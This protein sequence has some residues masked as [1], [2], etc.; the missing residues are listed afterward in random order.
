MSQASAALLYRRLLMA[1]RLA[2]IRPFLIPHLHLIS[3]RSVHTSNQPPSHQVTQQPNQ[4]NH[5]HNNNNN[6]NSNHHRRQKEI[7]WSKLGVLNEKPPSDADASWLIDQLKLTLDAQSIKGMPRK[8]VFMMHASIVS[9][10]LLGGIEPKAVV[11]YLCVFYRQFASLS[12]RLHLL[13]VLNIYAENI[14]QQRE[15]LRPKYDF[16]IVPGSMPANRVI[17]FIYRQLFAPNSDITGDN[18][19]ELMDAIIAEIARDDNSL[20]EVTR[21]NIGESLAKMDGRFAKEDP[22]IYNYIAANVGKI[23]EKAQASVKRGLIFRLKQMLQRKDT[24]YDKLLEF[25]DG[26]VPQKNPVTLY[27]DIMGKIISMTPDDH[28]IEILLK[29]IR[30][31]LVPVN[32]KELE[33]SVYKALKGDDSRL[34]YTIL[35]G[36]EPPMQLNM[37]SRMRQMTEDVDDSSLDSLIKEPLT[38]EESDLIAKFY[39]R[40]IISVIL[41]SYWIPQRDPERCKEYLEVLKRNITLATNR[42][43]QNL[44]LYNELVLYT[45]IYLGKFFSYKQ[46]DEELTKNQSKELYGLKDLPS[47]VSGLENRLDEYHMKHLPRWLVYTIHHHNLT[48]ILAYMDPKLRLYYMGIFFPKSVELFKSLGLMDI[49]EIDPAQ[50]SESATPRYKSLVLPEAGLHV[51]QLTFLYKDIFIN[52]GDKISQSDA[53]DLFAKLTNYMSSHTDSPLFE[54]KNIPA[55]LDRFIAFGSIR[56]YSQLLSEVFKIVVDKN[57]F[58]DDLE[59]LASLELEALMKTDPQLSVEKLDEFKKD[60]PKSKIHYKTYAIMIKGLSLSDSSD[61]AYR[62]YVHFSKD[63]PDFRLRGDSRNLLPLIK[64]FHWRKDSSRFTKQFEG[65]E[66]KPEVH[67][68]V[69]KYNVKLYDYDTLDDSEQH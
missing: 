14:A 63:Y 38:E 59:G 32:N 10:S 55:I 60:Y 42:E 69:D 33:R 9:S 20:T 1:S 44:T 46:L 22:E 56:G 41:T 43:S 68:K 61:A 64:G 13:E 27:E 26:L 57:Y 49:L 21:F 40:N 36:R 62:V 6:N 50:I 34:I 25:L 11:E 15:T 67:V 12:S 4:R 39:P 37:V 30:C 7:N 19:R 66:K 45:D 53:M 16:V 8:A 54:N 65:A 17:A 3:W 52:L 47:I 58:Y 18:V 48:G 2:A 29:L 28:R 51:K 5:R 35:H 24:S 31:G 23:S